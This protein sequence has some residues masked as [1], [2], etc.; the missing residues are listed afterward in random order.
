MRSTR[1]W[2]WCV[3]VGTVAIG[4]AMGFQMCLGV[5]LME[6]NDFLLLQMILCGDFASSMASKVKG[7]V[8]M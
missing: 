1:G 2:S 7:V 4:A 8:S 5:L 6:L 3:V